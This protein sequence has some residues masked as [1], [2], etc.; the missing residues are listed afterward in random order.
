MVSTTILIKCFYIIFLF[1]RNEKMSGNNVLLIK[2]IIKLVFQIVFVGL[3][4]SRG[5]TRE[6]REKTKK[7]ANYKLAFLI[8]FK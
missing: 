5:R 3:A 2:N 8:F 6:K 7:R 1:Q 4:R